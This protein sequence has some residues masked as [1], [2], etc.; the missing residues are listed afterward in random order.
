MVAL[1][2]NIVRRVLQLDKRRAMALYKHD[3]ARFLSY[4]GG[5]DVS[6]MGHCKPG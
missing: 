2:K 5:G 1:L 4:S 6:H 3:C